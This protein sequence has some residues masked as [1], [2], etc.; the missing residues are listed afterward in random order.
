MGP[1][2][3]GKTVMIRQT[4]QQLI[5]DGVDPKS[6]LYCSL[7]TPVYIGLGLE[8]LFR[9]F[10]EIHGHALMARLYVFFD[11]V[12][13]LK[14]WE[15]HLKSFVDSFT[16]TKAVAS[17]SAAAA[18]R[19][20]S[21]ESGAGRFTDFAL[22]PLN[23]SEF[24]EFDADEEGRQKSRALRG[25]VATL[26]QS[27]IEFLNAKFE[28]FVLFGGFPE[29]TRASL[30]AREYERYVGGDILD[31]VLLRDLPSLYGIDDPLE[32]QRVFTLLALNTGQEVNL[33][34]L[35]TGSGIAKNTLK[36]YFQYLEATQLIRRL[37]RIDRSGHRLKRAVAFK[38]YLTSASLKTALFGPTQATLPEFG[39]LVETAVFGELLQSAL[40]LGLGY[41]RWGDK[42]VDF[43]FEAGPLGPG[44]IDAIEVKWSNHRSELARAAQ[45]LTSML[46]D[47]R[48]ATAT[49]LTKSIDQGVERGLRIQPVSK[50]CLNW[51]IFGG[52]LGKG[53][54]L[55]RARKFK[56]LEG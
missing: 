24:L 31:K 38:V 41:G 52:T 16:G 26:A 4:I 44:F 15:V 25:E 12:Q 42:E 8:A 37:D 23:F 54:I 46:D 19:Y 43:V 35:S 5:D 30:S 45:H 7:E 28:K 13:Y 34:K 36:K 20:A 55:A 10:C 48:T 14:Q 21:N 40:S 47:G 1:R 53:D 9:L 51:P 2:R 49:L 56:T 50:F 29:P 39:H 18:L 11:E 22:P 27:D 32:L 3:V 6:I 33:E 17:G